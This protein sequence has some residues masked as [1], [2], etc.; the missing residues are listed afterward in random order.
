MK[1]IT[2][3]A[4]HLLHSLNPFSALDLP[5]FGITLW[6]LG[7][8]LVRFNL[9][10]IIFWRSFTVYINYSECVSVTL[11]T[12]ISLCY[13][14]PDIYSLFVIQKYKQLNVQLKGVL[15]QGSHR[16]G[17]WWQIEKNHI[18]KIREFR[19]KVEKTRNLEKDEKFNKIQEM[20]L[21]NI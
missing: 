5:G 7:T 12:L 2:N 16:P 15:Y 17:I 13:V 3:V 19:K 21:V 4:L 9:V 10:H 6:T 14:N 8:R 20:K 1:Y 18:W 11:I